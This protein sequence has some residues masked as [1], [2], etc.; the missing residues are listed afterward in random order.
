MKILGTVA[1]GFLWLG[2][3]AGAQEKPKVTVAADGTGDYRTV[4]LAVDAA[5]AQ[6]EV[7]RIKPGT[8]QREG[9]RF[10][11]RGLSCEGMGKTPAE[12][13]LAFDDSAK[14]AGGTGK[15][16]SVT[17]TG[18][19]FTAENLTIQ[20]DWEKKNARMGEGAQAV[21]LMISGDREVLRHVRLLGYQDTL[22]AGSKY[23]SCAGG[24]DGRAVP[25][26]E[27]AV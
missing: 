24:C 4:Q 11:R 23:V 18:D 22:Y 27:D 13:V 26:G 7:I 1:V 16:G 19:D 21:A 17:V 10:R 14:S 2:G 6:G 20:N 8:Y 15:S 12:V 5:P 9:G 25:G 3:V